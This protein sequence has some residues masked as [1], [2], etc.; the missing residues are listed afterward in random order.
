MAQ[1]TDFEELSFYDPTVPEPER[2]EYRHLLI[3][4][5]HPTIRKVPVTWLAWR[6]GWRL[7]PITDEEK[8]AYHNSMPGL[9]SSDLPMLNPPI[10]LSDGSLVTDIRDLDQVRTK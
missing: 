4:L 5:G 2:W 9:M 7:D 3:Q 1:E 10:R 6:I 8:W